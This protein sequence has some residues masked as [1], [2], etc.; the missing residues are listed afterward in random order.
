M[1]NNYKNLLGDS[2]SFYLPKI[3]GTVRFYTQKGRYQN[4]RII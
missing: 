2:G 3:N 4:V 1:L